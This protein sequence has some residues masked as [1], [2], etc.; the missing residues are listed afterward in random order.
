[1]ANRRNDRRNG[2]KAIYVILAIVAVALMT[3]MPVLEAII[4]SVLLLGL[5]AV[6]ILGWDIKQELSGSPNSVMRDLIDRLIHSAGGNTFADPSRRARDEVQ[7]V[8][9]DAMARAGHVIAENSIHLHDIG[10]LVY[11]DLKTPKIYRTSDIPTDAAYLRPFVVLNQPEMPGASGGGVLRFSLIDSKRKL[12]YTSRA[13][14]RLHPGQNFV[15]PPTWLPLT[16]QQPDGAWMLHVTL[17]DTPFAI[18]NFQWLQV[19]G[20]QR[21]RFNGDGEI[22]ARTL[23]KLG[24]PAQAPL[25]LDELLADQ[26]D[27][28]IEGIALQ[29]TESRR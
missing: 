6:L 2:P 12:R 24:G 19:G 22:D 3:Q 15:T 29:A 26:G 25:S 5:V 9:D 23:Q 7:A 14:Y 10:L 11:D 16:D 8:A 21:A 4:L 27:V 20:A 17:S 1:M 13:K 28:E 18:L